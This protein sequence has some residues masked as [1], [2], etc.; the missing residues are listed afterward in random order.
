MLHESL[1]WRLKNDESYSPPN[2]H[3]G[4]LPPC[5]KHKGKIVDVVPVKEDEDE[6]DADHQT[7]TIAK[8]SG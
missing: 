5:L 6:Y 1:L 4:W 2:N 8:T 7:Y 3:G